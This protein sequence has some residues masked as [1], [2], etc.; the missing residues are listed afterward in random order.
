MIIIDTNALILI[1]IGSIDPRIF[2]NHKRTSLYD[3]ED[4]EYLIKIVGDM[5]KLVVLP[6][7]WTE[8]DNLLN[9]FR[10]QYKDM[11]ISILKN[12]TKEITEQYI[13]T[14]DAV[15]NDTIYDLGI[16]DTQILTIAKNCDFLITADSKLADYA[17]ANGVK[18]V[19]LVK[20][21]NE[22]INE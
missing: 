21:K 8:A 6:N 3:E 14:S 13:K 5:K 10:G 2:K 15:D 20:R 11:Y 22:L 18:V 4:Y 9:D 16:T 12:V 7:I 1:I 19:D 17:N